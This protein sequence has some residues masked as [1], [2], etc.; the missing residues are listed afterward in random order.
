[1]SLFTIAEILTAIN[2]ELIKGKIDDSISGISIDTRTIQPGEAFIAL[3]G[4]NFDGHDFLNHALAK[5]AKTLIVKPQYRHM[6]EQVEIANIIT[7]DSPLKALQD[8]AHY[9]LNKLKPK[10]I[11]V[12]GSTGKTTTKELI[13]SVLSQKY[14]V[15]K[16]A[17]NFNNEI[18]LPL[19]ILNLNKDHQ[20]AVLEMGMSGLGEIKR[21][22]QIAP[23]DIAII[24][25]IGLTH[26]EKLGSIEGIVQAKGELLEALNQE[27]LAI[28]NGDDP[29][30]KKLIAKAKSSLCLVGEKDKTVDLR[31]FNIQSAGEQGVK[32]ALEQNGES[33]D[34]FVP[35]PGKH[36][37]INS[38]FA[39]AVGLSLGLS[40]EEIATGLAQAKTERMRLNILENRMGVKFINDAY[41]ANPTSVQAALDVLVE[42]QGKRKFAVLGDMLELGTLAEFAH[43]EVGRSV[44]EKGID[45]LFTLGQLGK[46]IG[47]EALKM[48]A[49]PE[50][51]YCFSTIE[52][53]ADQLKKHLSFGDLVLVKGSRGMGMEK[54]ILYLENKEERK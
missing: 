30:T 7:V 40:L 11:G 35:I 34:L 41:N 9:H 48:G 49:S 50:T 32:F 18:G 2:G 15:L 25:N 53:L 8:L 22:A 23:P 38:L 33:F 10:V 46:F 27:G 3:A 5:G 44:V 20:I 39:V 54:I 28:L 42:I 13:A 1:M 51:V 24:T 37:V 45:Y 21:L 12:T 16:T 4:E 36:N 14:G 29:Q 31:A 43:R 26:L 6:I 52:E 17:G 47:E 19:T